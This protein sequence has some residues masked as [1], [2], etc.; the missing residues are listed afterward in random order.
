MKLERDKIAFENQYMKMWIKDH[1]LYCLY[2]PFLNVTLEIAQ[3][4]VEDRIKFTEGKTYPLFSDIRKVKY[5]DRSA[6]MYLSKE[7]SLKNISAESLMISSQSD[8]F[9]S[10]LYIKINNPGIPTEQFSNDQE[11]IVWLQQ[12]KGL[13]N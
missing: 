10:N 8:K 11:A 2:A 1:I 4:C 12:F 6:R 5:I 7:T 9:L 13:T 3:A